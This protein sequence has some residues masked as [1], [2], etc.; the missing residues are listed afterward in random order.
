LAFLRARLEGG[1]KGGWVE[2]GLSCNFSGV[3]R[4]WENYPEVRKTEKRSHSWGMAITRSEGEVTGLMI[5]KNREM[6]R[7]AGRRSAS[8]S[9]VIE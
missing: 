8:S 4:D 9:I 3:G 6:R 7:R 1:K 5:C 2:G